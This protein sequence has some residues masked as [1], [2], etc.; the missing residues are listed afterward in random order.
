MSNNVKI[1]DSTGTLVVDLEQ[2]LFKA[3]HLSYEDWSK[4]LQM[5]FTELKFHDKNGTFIGGFVR[6]EE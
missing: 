6:G 3:D 4:I 5:D 2:G 1:Y